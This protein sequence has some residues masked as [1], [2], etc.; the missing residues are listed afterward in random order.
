SSIWDTYE[1]NSDITPGTYRIVHDGTDRVLGLQG[2]DNKTLILQSHQDQGSD[3]SLVE[4][5]HWLLLGS[6]DGFIFKHC[7]QGTYI[8]GVLLTAASAQSVY[9][10][11]YPTT[12]AILSKKDGDTLRCAI[13]IPIDQ[14]ETWLQGRYVGLGVTPAGLCIIPFS[15]NE[16]PDQMWRLERLD[17]T[18]VEEDYEYRVCELER[19]LRE[20]NAR[21]ASGESNLKTMRQQLETKETELENI[22]EEL[23]NQATELE[24]VRSELIKQTAELREQY[25]ALDTFKDLLGAKELA[26]SEKGSDIFENEAICEKDEEIYQEERPQNLKEEVIE[27]AALNE[28]DLQTTTQEPQCEDTNNASMSNTTVLVPEPA[29]VPEIGMQTVQPAS[30]PLEQKLAELGWDFD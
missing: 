30:A 7:R 4:N 29:L 1:T 28:Q 17:D 12:W 9:A 13:T 14:N 16:E 3:P 8:T 19:E 2:E 25:R 26:V 21:W 6:G 24:S 22:R 20:A 5:D 11:R 27:E 10:T 23:S 15:E 18:P